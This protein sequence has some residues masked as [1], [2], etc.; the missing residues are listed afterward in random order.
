VL[1]GRIAS[2]GHYGV[3]FGLL[4][5][6]NSLGSAL[7]P[8]LSGALYD[9]TGSYTVIYVSA[10]GL[11]GIASPPWLASASSPGVD[12]PGASRGMTHA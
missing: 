4:G 12:P 6:G 11:L 1:V 3:V 8:L 10:I 2:P 9:W 7:G 5:I